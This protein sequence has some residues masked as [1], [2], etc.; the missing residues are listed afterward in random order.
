MVPYSLYT[1]STIVQ[2][3]CICRTAPINQH[4]PV[5]SKRPK[6]YRDD[7]SITHPGETKSVKTSEEEF[8]ADSPDLHEKAHSK[9]AAV[10]LSGTL[11]GGF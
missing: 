5:G 2:E 7:S 3:R 6:P 8:A 1:S 4:C 9:S 10:N 11:P